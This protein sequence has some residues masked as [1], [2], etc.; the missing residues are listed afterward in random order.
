[1]Q[2]ALEAHDVVHEEDGPDIQRTTLRYPAPTGSGYDSTKGRI[3]PG[4]EANI[5][6]VY[7]QQCWLIEDRSE[8]PSAKTFAQLQPDYIDEWIESYEAHLTPVP[9]PAPP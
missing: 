5:Q 3:D 2:K 4:S 8:P 7:K 9:P 6:R 1:M